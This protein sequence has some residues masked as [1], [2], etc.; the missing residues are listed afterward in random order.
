MSE[1]GWT[2]SNGARCND[3]GAGRDVRLAGGVAVGGTHFCGRRRSRGP[4]DNAGRRKGEGGERD[5]RL[6]RLHAMA[7]VLRL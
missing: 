1:A 3:Q 2:Y 4:R 5:G 7:P 6:P